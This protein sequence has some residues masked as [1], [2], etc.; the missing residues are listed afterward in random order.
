MVNLLM[1]KSGNAVLFTFP[2]NVKY[3]GE[4]SAAQREARE[5][6]LGIWSEKGL[7]EL[8][9]DYRKKHPRIELPDRY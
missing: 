5:K 6:R 8:P 2:P 3:T 1:V 4:L 7:K 9:G